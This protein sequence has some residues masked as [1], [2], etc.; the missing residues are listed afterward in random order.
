MLDPGL[1]RVILPTGL[2]YKL[3]GTHR[4]IVLKR[5][6]IKRRRRAPAPNALEASGSSDVV[7]VPR[8]PSG[9]TSPHAPTLD[10][11]SDKSS[12][13]RLTPHA[14]TPGSP[15]LCSQRSIHQPYAVSAPKPKPT[16]T[17]RARARARDRDRDREAALALIQVGTAPRHA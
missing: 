15:L 1:T 13:S 4:P 17:D 3:H 12:S 16:E 2:Y 7:I 6:T 10:S 14:G 8:N 11:A 5:N 9:S